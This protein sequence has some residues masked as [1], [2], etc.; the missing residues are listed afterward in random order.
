MK[1][2]KRARLEASGWT[3][4]T[5]AEF[6]ALDE[7]ESA[8]VDLRLTLGRSLRDRRTRR[9]LTQSELAR[10]LGSSQSRVAKMEAADASVSLDL[11]I[12]SLVALGARSKEIARAIAP[13]S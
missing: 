8:I 1:P 4:G 5:A 9:G 10:Q 13:G 3:V 11:L 2:A 6:L 7:I 12:R